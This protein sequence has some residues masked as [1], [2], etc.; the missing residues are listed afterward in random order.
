MMV[1][2]PTLFTRDGGLVNESNEVGGG[3]MLASIIFAE[4]LFST[5]IFKHHITRQNL[6]HIKAFVYMKMCYN[7][8]HSRIYE[9]VLKKDR[10]GFLAISPTLCKHVVIVTTT[11]TICIISNITLTT[12]SAEMYI[13]PT[14][15]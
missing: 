11:I 8:T 3:G 4:K 2:K 14:C 7:V 12:I 1:W 15:Y 9:N 10:G 5:T 6:R 13:F